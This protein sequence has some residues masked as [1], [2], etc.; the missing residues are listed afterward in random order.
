MKRKMKNVLIFTI[1]VLLVYLVFGEER[2]IKY[3]I[4]KIDKVDTVT[5]TYGEQQNTFD[6][7]DEMFDLLSYSG[8]V[9]EVDNMFERLFFPYCEE[10][11]ET[12]LSITY[13][14]EGNK[15][16][17]AKVYYNINQSD[18]YVLYMN[19]VYW[20]TGESIE[21]LFELLQLK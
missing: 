17:K 5:M 11:E 8:S 15:Y 19:N 3:N 16:G 20:T 14:R 1:I 12:E 4:I 7:N 13:F 21:E 6:F 18:E 2:Y 9:I 10:L